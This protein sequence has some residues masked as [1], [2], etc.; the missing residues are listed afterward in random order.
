MFALLAAQFA[1]PLVRY[2]AIAGGL[3][4]LIGAIWVHGYHKGQRVVQN[5]WDAAIAQASV[6]A[7][8]ES[9]KAAAMESAVVKAGDLAERV[10]EAK[11]EIVKQKVVRYAKKD[12]TPL[13]AATIAIYDELIRLP[14]EAGHS[15]PS[16][17]PSAG[18]PEISRGGVAIETVT[19]IQD[20]EGNEIELTTEEL[21]Q[22]AT[23]F[24][25]LFAKMKNKYGVFS[26]WNEGRE[27]LELERITKD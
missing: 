24:S 8:N 3:A 7:V 27:K 19:R 12:P 17:D 11:A 6:N 16:T 25:K 15:L 21:A 2:G 9:V 4:L 1:K 14:N 13:R 26:E 20:E 10:I 18:T 5:S 23:D 22:A